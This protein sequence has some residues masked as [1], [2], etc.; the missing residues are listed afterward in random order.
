[1][2]D[3]ASR[4]SRIP[5]MRAL[6]FMAPVIAGGLLLFA[7]IAFTATWHRL[8]ALPGGATVGSGWPAVLL[9]A[10]VVLLLF[11]ATVMAAVVRPRGR[12]VLIGV[13]AVLLIAVVPLALSGADWPLWTAGVSLLVGLGAATRVT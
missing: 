13:E 7:A 6:M 10:T 4:V 12:L 9:V 2:T 1:M 3:R 8:A 11:A 5:V